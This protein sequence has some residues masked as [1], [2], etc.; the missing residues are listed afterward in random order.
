[1]NEI[2]VRRRE[3][4]QERR[5]RTR[6]K[7]FEAAAQVIAERGEK[8]A[9]IDDFIQAAGVARGTFYNY[10]STRDELLDDLW[11]Q[12]GRNPFRKIQ[13]ACADLPDPAER[14]VAQ[15]RLVLECA[16]QQPAW[17][18][19]VYA[20]SA[21][22]DSVNDDLLAYPEPDLRAGLNS[23]RFRYEELSSA[24]DMIVG[25]VRAALHA[26]LSE[27]RPPRYAQSLCEMLLK[28]LG[29]AEREAQEISERPLPPLIAEEHGD[30]PHP[31]T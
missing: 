26:V 9:T 3:I 11:K 25:S 1:M 31:D 4:G 7:L 22:A 16:A 29:L 12:I 21:D 23:G 2:N 28:G 18:W 24:G 17:G 27:T 20:L 8:K 30:G 14:L 15:A 13:A 5:E 19:L 6:Q 10:Y